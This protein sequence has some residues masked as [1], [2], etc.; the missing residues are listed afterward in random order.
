MPQALSFL[1]KTL[2][3]TFVA[4][5]PDDIHADLGFCQNTAFLMCS[6]YG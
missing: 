3:Y 1:E 4:E 5:S 6:A 2:N